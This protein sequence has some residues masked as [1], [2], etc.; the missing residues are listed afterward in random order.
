MSD[1]LHVHWLGRR[2][3]ICWSKSL[4]LI[5][6]LYSCGCVWEVHVWVYCV[7][8]QHSWTQQIAVAVGAVTAKLLRCVD[9][10]HFSARRLLVIEAITAELMRCVGWSWLSGRHLRV[11]AAETAELLSCVGWS[12]RSYLNSRRGFSPEIWFLT[13][14]LLMSYIYIYGAPS[15][16]RNAN[17]I[18]IYMDLHLAMLKAVSLYLLHNVSTLNHCRVVSCVTFV[19]KHFAS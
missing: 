12:Y 17:V 3:P 16:A 5:P 9:W 8:D 13:L 11:T 6:F 1:E 15:K 7:G 10:S 14:S 2:D 19:C 18:Y 4:A